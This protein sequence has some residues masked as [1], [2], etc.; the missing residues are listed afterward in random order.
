MLEARSA[1]RA[2]KTRTGPA[3]RAAPERPNSSSVSRE[4]VARSHVA[5][6]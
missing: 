5:Q 1:R 3:R 4:A 6:V 2:T